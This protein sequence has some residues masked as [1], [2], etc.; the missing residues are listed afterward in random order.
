[1][2]IQPLVVVAVLGVLFA[3][4]AP[5]YAGNEV[6]VTYY[7]DVLPI[8]Q[9]NCQTCHRPTGQNIS[10]L[11]APMSFMDYKETRPWARAIARKVESKEMP[12]WFATAP[13]ACSRTSAD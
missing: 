12:P 10:G 9:D 5:G 11:I 2:K 7:K 6:A 8:I 1:M 4:A 13:R 3:G